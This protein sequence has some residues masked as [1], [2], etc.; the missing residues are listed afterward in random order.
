MS[1]FDEIKEAIEQLPPKE[2]ASL[3]VWLETFDARQ[4]DARIEQ[5][6]TSGKF[7]KFAEYSLKNFREGR[8]RE[9]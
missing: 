4:F 6:A 7:D 8:V 9:L 5:D 3:R 1:E 2:L